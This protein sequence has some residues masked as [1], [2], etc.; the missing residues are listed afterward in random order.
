ME[1]LPVPTQLCSSA[2]GQVQEH[3][4][5]HKTQHG[6]HAPAQT[7]HLHRRRTQ[8][9][10]Q[11]PSWNPSLLAPL[12]ALRGVSCNEPFQNMQELLG[13]IPWPYLASSAPSQYCVG[14]PSY[15]HTPGSLQNHGT[16]ETLLEFP[17]GHQYVQHAS[18]M[19]TFCKLVVNQLSPPGVI[20]LTPLSLPI[21]GPAHIPAAEMLVC[22]TIPNP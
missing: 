21:A 18:L 19:T 2:A 9:R 16:S 12:H 4:K 1:P 14:P 13:R 11:I 3:Q 22:R 7:L 8:V 10:G 17:P 20:F 15:S 6:R 5:L